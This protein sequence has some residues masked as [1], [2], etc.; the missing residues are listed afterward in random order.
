MPIEKITYILIPLVLNVQ[1]KQTYRDT[2]SMSGC[3]WLEIETIKHVHNFL[4]MEI[5]EF[6][7]VMRM[8]SNW[9]LMIAMQLSQFNENHCI[10]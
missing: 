1:K 10:L 4:Y 9:I 5:R 7:G 2:K 8:F 6:I 3:L